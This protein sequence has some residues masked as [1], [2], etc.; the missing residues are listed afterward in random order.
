MFRPTSAAHQAWHD[1]LADRMA[2]EL[3]CAACCFSDH[4]RCD[5]GRRLAAAEQAAHD[6]WFRERFGQSQGAAA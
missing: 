1:R 6:V 4:P 3:S 5:E 2:H